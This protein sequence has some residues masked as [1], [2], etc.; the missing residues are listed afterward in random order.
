MKPSVELGRPKKGVRREPKPG[1]R[2]SVQHVH[3]LPEVGRLKQPTLVPAIRT[4]GR[5]VSG[6]RVT[7]EGVR[8]R[9]FTGKM[10]FAKKLQKGFDRARV[11]G[12]VSDV[13]G[14]SLRQ[15]QYN[16]ISSA[17]VPPPK[18]PH[19]DSRYR[20]RGFPNHGPFSFCTAAGPSMAPAALPTSGR[21]TPALRALHQ[22]VA[23]EEAPAGGR[24]RRM[25]AAEAHLR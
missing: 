24:G 18:D 9:K 19:L 20:A 1:D 6:E 10:R 2:G 13:A 11:G 8:R 4:F 16:R 5:A 22:A 21:K 15:A 23:Q 14:K 7:P 17:A 25:A 12:Y 3:P